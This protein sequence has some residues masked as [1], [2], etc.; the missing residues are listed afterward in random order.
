MREFSKELTH[1]KEAALL[2]NPTVFTQR[3]ETGGFRQ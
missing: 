3:S 2:I 1:T